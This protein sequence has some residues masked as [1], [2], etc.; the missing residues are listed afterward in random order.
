MSQKRPVKAHSQCCNSTYRFLGPAPSLEI[1]KGRPDVKP[2]E[3]ME[4]EGEGGQ[5]CGFY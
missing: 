5:R 4:R 2:M 1:A 3:E